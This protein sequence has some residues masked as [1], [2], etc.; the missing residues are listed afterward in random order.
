MET[1]G[2]VGVED[3]PGCTSGSWSAP[4]QVRAKAAIVRLGQK[5][6]LLVKA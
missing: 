3:G 1:P 2:N 6:I 4:G 5:P